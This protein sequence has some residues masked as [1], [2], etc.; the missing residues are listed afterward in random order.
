[1]GQQGVKRELSDRDYAVV[2][3]MAAAGHRVA[4]IARA[5]DMDTRTFREIRGRDERAVQAFEAGRGELHGTLMSKLIEH[6]KAG[7]TAELIFAL[8]SLF[9]Y[10][11]RPQPQQHEHTHRVLIQ[12]PAALDR[13]RYAKEI[14]TIE[15]GKLRKLPAADRQELAQLEG[16]PP[17][18]RRQVVPASRRA[19]VVVDAEVVEPEP[20]PAAE[21]AKPQRKPLRVKRRKRRPA[22]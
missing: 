17:A 6:A 21:P 2:A 5:L 18:L 14:K 16:L 15:P 8:K 22:R 11:D 19:E 4:D 7:R 1:M 3:S 10:S 12:L 9:Q 20:E 13:E